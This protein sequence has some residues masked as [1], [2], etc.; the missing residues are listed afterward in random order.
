MVCIVIPGT[1]EANDR[2]GTR[3]QRRIRRIHV[4]LSLR[5]ASEQ[6]GCIFFVFFVRCNSFL[7]ELR[8][9]WRLRFRRLG[10]GVPLVIHPIAHRLE[11][12]PMCL[13]SLFVD[14]LKQVVRRLLLCQAV[15]GMYDWNL[16]R[17]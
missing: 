15:L 6:P 9:G 12:R 11:I 7:N 4:L 10:H 17:C 13:D 8:Q 1:E 3:R 5:N 14:Y 16:F 2:T